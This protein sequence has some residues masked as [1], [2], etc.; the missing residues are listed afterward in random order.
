MDIQ[1]AVEILNRN[2]HR[3]HSDWYWWSDV[4]IA[5][6]GPD[7]AS[8]IGNSLH[9]EQ[10]VIIAQ[11]YVDREQRQVATGAMDLEAIEARVNAATEGPWF[12]GPDDATDCPDH[13]H[14]GLALVD[15]GRSSDWPVARLCEW[16][17]AKFIVEAITD[18]PALIAEVKRL[19]GEIRKW[20]G[21][22]VEQVHRLVAERVEHGRRIAALEAELAALRAAAASPGREK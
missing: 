9:I 13:S 10:A 17:N 18:I 8:T 7:D 20:D 14:S 11:Y 4:E 6:D 5:F 3:G 19:Q 22:N 12:V 16:Q 1:Q 2:N 21:Y 15:T